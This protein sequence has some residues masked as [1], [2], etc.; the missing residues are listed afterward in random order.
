MSQ[1]KVDEYKKKKANR[2]KIAKKEKRML[3]LEKAAAI[4]VCLLAVAWVGYSAY[5]KVTENQETQTTQTE[6]DVSAINDYTNELAEE[7]TSK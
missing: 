6:M 3:M 1:K 2:S 5:G 7:L 4:V